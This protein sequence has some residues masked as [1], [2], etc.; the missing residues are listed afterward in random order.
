MKK[1]FPKVKKVS[2]FL[3]PA[4]FFFSLGCFAMYMVLKDKV[5]VQ[6]KLTERIL[7]NCINSLQASDQINK[8]CVG[9]YNTATSCISNF[10]KCS[11]K[12][13]SKK[14]V[15]YNQ[16]RQKA[17]KALQYTIIETGNIVNDAKKILQ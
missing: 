4:I 13:E 9:I 11:I 6:G 14:I 16:E 15:E 17:E 12:S 8:S 1:I 2:L 5:A 10:N 3:L 7:N